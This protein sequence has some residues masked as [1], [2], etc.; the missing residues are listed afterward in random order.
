[1]EFLNVGLIKRPANWLIVATMFMFGAFALH[2]IL[3]LVH[4]KN[5]LL[6]TKH[7]SRAT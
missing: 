3:Q 6:V 4:G 2:F 5:F 1:M 7:P